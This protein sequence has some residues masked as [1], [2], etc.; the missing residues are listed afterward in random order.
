MGCAVHYTLVSLPKTAVH[1]WHKALVCT[2]ML[3]EL[4]DSVHS[5]R[6]KGKDLQA[7]QA[8]QLSAHNHKIHNY[9]LDLSAAA[10]GFLDQASAKGQH[11]FLNEFT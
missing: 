7:C 10:H 8:A 1:V 5:P 4:K 11:T 6:T 3:V 9:A 2:A